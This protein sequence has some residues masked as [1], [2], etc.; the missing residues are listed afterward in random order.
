M[1]GLVGFQKIGRNG[2][3]HKADTQTKRAGECPRAGF[4]HDRHTWL[5]KPESAGKKRA[6]W[7]WKKRNRHTHLL[8]TRN[9]PTATAADTPHFQTGTK[10]W[11]I[12]SNCFQKKVYDHKIQDISGSTPHVTGASTNKKPLPPGALLS[13]GSLSLRILCF[14]CILVV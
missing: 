4:Q 13:Q 2:H 8:E 3:T 7:R 10:E 12:G 1:K 14:S 6:G 11:Q 9:G 5:D